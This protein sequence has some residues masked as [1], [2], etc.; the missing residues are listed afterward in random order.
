[1][2]ASLL[3]ASD[4]AQKPRS[5]PDQRACCAHTRS[6]A[7]TERHPVRGI[8]QSV[9]PEQQALLVK[10]EEIPGFMPAMTM[11]F[12]VTPEVLSQVR[13]G[14]SLTGKITQSADGRWQLEDIK[15]TKP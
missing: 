2:L 15:K 7:E 12:Q 13:S 6:P 10:H 4:Q 9:L 14:D 5:A 11:M 8:V 1:V 3:F